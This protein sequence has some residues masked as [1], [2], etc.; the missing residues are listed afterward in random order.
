MT[1]KD[2]NSVNQQDKDAAFSPERQQANG[3]VVVQ[4][5]LGALSDIH[6]YGGSSSDK[7]DDEI[8]VNLGKGSSS[9]LCKSHFPV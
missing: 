5:A 3:V 1:D 8:N 4:G 2:V 6:A 7:D 9:N